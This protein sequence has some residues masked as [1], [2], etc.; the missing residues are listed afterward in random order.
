[1]HDKNIHPVGCHNFTK[2]I[3]IA[4]YEIVKKKLG[5]DLVD[6]CFFQIFYKFFTIL[7]YNNFVNWKV[8]YYQYFYIFLQF[9]TS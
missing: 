7:Y 5:R 8:V 9:Y 1:M 3:T 6:C 4:L 2:N